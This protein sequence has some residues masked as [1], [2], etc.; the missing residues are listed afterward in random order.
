MGGSVLN[1]IVRRAEDVR[2]VPA[3]ARTLYEYQGISWPCHNP[4]A[5][6]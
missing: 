6:S 5:R 4:C 1:G 2:T 3:Y